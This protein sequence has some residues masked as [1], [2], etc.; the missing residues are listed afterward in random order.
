MVIFFIVKKTWMTKI[1]SLQEFIHLFMLFIFN[2]WEQFL[3]S[4]VSFSCQVNM[5]PFLINN[6]LFFKIPGQ[7]MLSSLALF[8]WEIISK[9]FQFLY[10]WATFGIIGNKMQNTFLSNQK[11]DIIIVS[12]FLWKYKVLSKHIYAYVRCVK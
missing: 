3:H 12:F 6:A 5:H 2:R 8:L 4:S 7:D 9:C 11:V 10:G 1:L